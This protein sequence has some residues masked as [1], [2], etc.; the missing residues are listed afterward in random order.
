MARCGYCG[1]L[2]WW[3][4]PWGFLVTPVQILRNFAGMVAGPSASQPSAQ[5]EK[6]VKLNLA[7]QLLTA[8]QDDRTAGND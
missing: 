4:F 5:L 7:H 2:G 1:M 6:L 3:G 8:P